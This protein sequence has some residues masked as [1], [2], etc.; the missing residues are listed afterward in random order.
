MFDILKNIPFVRCELEDAGQAAHSA[1]IQQMDTATYRDW[2]AN[3]NGRIDTIH[4]YAE[5]IVNV[6]SILFNTYLLY[7][8]KHYSTFEIKMYKYLL[9]IDALLDLSLAIC[10]LIVQ[11][12]VMTAEGFF[13][14]IANGFVAGH[15]HCWDTRLTNVIIGV[16]AIGYSITAF[17]VNAYL[18]EVVEEFQPEGQNTR[19]RMIAS[20]LLF[21]TTCNGSIVVVIC[22]EMRIMKH[23]RR[24]GDPSVSTNTTQK[25]HKEFHRALLAMVIPFSAL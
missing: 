2:T 7:I 19:W 3:G 4:H 23:F 8:I 18:S 22:C 20:L 9:T 12:V 11:P 14:M 1:A 17:M 15:S 5:T 21:S 16:V 6:L 24:I 13:I 25:L 10:I